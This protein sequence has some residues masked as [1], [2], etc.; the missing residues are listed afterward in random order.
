MQEKEDDK[1]DEDN[2][3]DQRF[4]DLVDGFLDEGRGVIGIFDHYALGQRGRKIAHH[5]PHRF[6][7]IHRIG[8]GGK[9]H[10]KARRRMTIKAAYTAVVLFGEFDCGNIGKVNGRPVRVGLQQNVPKVLNRFK[11]GLRRQGDRELLAFHHRLLTQTA[12]RHVCVLLGYGGGHV[13]RCQLILE[14]LFGVQPNAHCVFGAEN[15]DRPHPRRALYR[16]FNRAAQQVAQFK[17]GIAAVF[18]DKRPDH[19]DRVG[20]AG[21]GNALA[22]HGVRQLRFDQLQFVLDLHLRHVRINTIV[23]GQRYTRRTFAGG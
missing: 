16:V 5:F 23:K 15:I 11:L 1:K 2:R 12:D 10:R 8:T 17:R 20:R 6:G 22:C 21:H 13:R 19:Q 14:Q 3:L 4:I 7:G 9:V 18:A